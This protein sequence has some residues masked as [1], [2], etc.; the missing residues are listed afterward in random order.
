MA[1]VNSLYETSLAKYPKLSLRHFCQLAEVKYHRLRDYRQN[2]AVQEHKAQAKADQIEQIRQ[3][4]ELHPTYG[5]RLLHQ[6][7]KPSLGR[8]LIRRSLKVLALN[9]KQ[10]KK[11]RPKIPGVV[12]VTEWPAGRR[13][14]L[15]ATQIRLSSGTKLWVYIALDVSSRSCLV[16]R[17]VRHLCQ[18][19][20]SEVISQ[21]V[22]QL[23]QLGI[24]DPI[25]I[26]TDGGSDFTSHSFQ[27]MCKTLGTWIRA[28]VSQKGGMGI[29]ERLNRTFK[30]QFMF[31]HELS[32]FFT[33]EA[34]CS[35]FKHWYNTQRKHSAIGYSTPWA[36]LV[37]QVKS[38]L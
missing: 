9:P 26:Q 14:Q 3:M 21:A 23:K 31:R 25:V 38:H 36:Y 13:V 35:E 24:T 20:A 33:V 4:A 16:V 2:R 5:Y 1:E 27:A 10:I 11:T 7:L 6:E 8:E 30:Y 29:I 28:K 34:L 18:H 22:N 12:P 19:A 32:D 17:L 15:D 37:K